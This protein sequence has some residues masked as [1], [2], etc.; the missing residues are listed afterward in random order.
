MKEKVL[1]F[2][3][4]YFSIYFIL[5]IFPFPL[6]GFPIIVDNFFIWFGQNILGLDF[7]KQTNTGSGDTVFDFV[8]LTFVLLL[9]FILTIIFLFTKSVV[10]EKVVSISIIYAR[11]F[12]SCM[13]LSYGFAK[14]GDGQFGLPS[15]FRLDQSVGEMSPMGIL[16]T[17]MG[18]SPA[19]S[20]FAGI[21]QA[22]AGFLLL[23]RRT[24][25]L[26]ALMAFGVMIN[27][28]VLNFCYDVPVKIF[29]TN[30]ALIA[31][32]IIHNN[33][34]SILN[35]LLGKPSNISFVGFRF[36]KKWLQ[37]TAKILIILYI[38]ILTV[39]MSMS[40]ILNTEENVNEKFFAVYENE[41]KST[42]SLALNKMIIDDG[43]AQ[44]FY[45][46]D[47]I[48]SWDFKFDE[49]ENTLFFK[50]ADSTKTDVKFHFKFIEDNQIEFS[51]SE[52]SLG[53]FSITKKE[54]F[55]LFKRKFNWTNEYPYNR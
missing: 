8:K 31:L 10:K 11:Y 54:D 42:D 22:T 23:F 34:I 3:K 20:A 17:F 19:Y 50:A 55:E 7:I 41:K 48:V 37:V 38:L 46:N 25:V 33:W 30:L 6:F 35:F 4:L 49:K 53:K 18:S 52:K 29:S 44:I 15:L 14:F 27:I 26:G 16:W 2:I 39:G 43:Y 47:T 1:N 12:L 32:F 28:V 9:S 21:C 5:Y 40:R 51:D 45:K 13:L 36:K 24:S